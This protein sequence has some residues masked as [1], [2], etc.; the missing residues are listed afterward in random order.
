MKRPSRGGDGGVIGLVITPLLAKNTSFCKR[1][2]YD[3]ENHT[4]SHHDNHTPPPPR[5]PGYATVP[6]DDTIYGWPLSLVLLALLISD[7]Q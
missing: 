7:D 4:E 1:I 6:S 5:N 3:I 2:W